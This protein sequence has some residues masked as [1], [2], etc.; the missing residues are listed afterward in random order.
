VRPAGNRWPDNHSQPVV[1]MIELAIT[2]P[3]LDFFAPTT[4]VGMRP[5]FVSSIE[6]VDRI[7]G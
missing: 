7:N 2:V 5:D 6:S 4:K 1:Q 3:R